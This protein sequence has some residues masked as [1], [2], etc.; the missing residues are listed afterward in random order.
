V[1]EQPHLVVTGTG[2]A[3][4][5]PDECRL[6][7]ALHHMAESAADALDATAD[8][9]TRA[10]A[11]LAAVGVEHCEAR[12]VG[13]SLQ[14]VFD[15]SEQKV[16]ARIGTYQLDVVIRPVDATGKVLQVLSSTVGDGLQVR[17]LQLGLRDPEPLRAEARRL[18]V[19]D[20]QRRAEELSD[21]AGVRLGAILSIADE[22]ASPGIPRA[23]LRPMAATAMPVPI[24]GGDVSAAST[25]TLTYAIEE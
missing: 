5:T 13:L 1:P 6:H 3:S 20:A 9:A 8:L 4:G 19:A 2:V 11:A 7:V 10:L 12:T 23:A 15:Q 17:G 21:A 24:E 16:T 18:A 14:D 25:V 22:T